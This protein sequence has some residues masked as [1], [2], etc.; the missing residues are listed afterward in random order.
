MSSLRGYF[1]FMIRVSF[2]TTYL[3]QKRFCDTLEQA[4]RRKPAY[5][6]D[7]VFVF[8]RATLQGNVIEPEQCHAIA[9][10][11]EE[12]AEGELARPALV[13]ASRLRAA[14]TDET[15]FSFC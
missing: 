7:P 3:S 10:R 8:T 9:D 2:S 12:L 11:M 5:G 13:L 1:S 6:Q 14:A 15:T 4:A